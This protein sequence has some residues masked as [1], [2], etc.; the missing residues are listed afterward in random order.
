MNYELLWDIDEYQAIEEYK[1]NAF[2]YI[3]LFLNDNL[4]NREMKYNGKGKGIPRNQEEF[5]KALETIIML[6]K[7]IKKNYTLNGNKSYSERLYRGLRKNSNHLSFASTTNNLEVALSFIDGANNGQTDLDVLIEILPSNVPFLNVE[8]FISSKFGDLKE[9]EILFA[10]CVQK[11]EE[12]MPFSSFISSV[13]SSQ[14]SSSIKARLDKIKDLTCRRV[15]LIP[16]RQSEVN[17]NTSFDSLVVNFNQ[18]R[19]NLLKVISLDSS[20]KEYFEA[21]QELLEFKEQCSSFL[22]FQFNEIDKEISQTISENAN[23]RITIDANYTITQTRVGNTGQMFTIHDLNTNSEYYFKPSI[24]K[25]GES[26]T[27]R[28]YIQE[29]AYNT[30]KIINPSR[31][32]KCNVCN[33]NGT[34]GAIQDKIEIDLETTRQFRS[35]FNDNVGQLSPKLI[36]QIMDEYLVDFC[37]CNYDAHPDN[38]IIDKDGNLRGIDKEQSFRYLGEDQENDMLFSKNY[39]EQYGESET[40][41][42]FIFKKMASGEISYKYLDGLPFRAARLEQVNNEQYRNLFRNYAYS[43]TKTVQEAELLLDR[44]VDRKKSIVKK[45]DMLKNTFYND[46]YQQNNNV[47]Q[48]YVFTDSKKQR[49]IIHEL[50]KEN[51]AIVTL[52]NKLE[53]NAGEELKEQRREL[54]RE[55]FR[56]RAKA[57]GINPKQTANLDDLFIQ[58]EIIEQQNLER[59]EEIK[60][61]HR[62]TM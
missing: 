16:Q 40:I 26:K 4:T 37:L 38:F 46:S 8:P 55:Q 6:Y 34:F 19:E 33:I 44:I 60:Q 20:S 15:E 1:W 39:N 45:V 41:Y 11:I 43:K 47:E 3:N 9:S 32:V 58:Q 28:A 29:A 51:S 61:D 10:P 7:S 35:Y 22:I 23:D 59:I 50:S 53:S 54:R 62:M 27:Y 56:E 13:D 14:L 42:S 31:A 52:E 49:S 18:Y 17:P 24:N 25:K 12:E 5:R 2:K 57:M 30:Q 48:E 21:Y 36:S